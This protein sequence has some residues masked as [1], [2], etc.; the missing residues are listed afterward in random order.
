M[1]FNDDG[2]IFLKNVISKDFADFLGRYILL[3]RQVAKTYF[4]K[5]WIP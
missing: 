2:Y 3:K 1:N 5:K 4:D